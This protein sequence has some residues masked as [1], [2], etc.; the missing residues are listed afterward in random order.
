[1]DIASVIREAQQDP[2]VANALLDAVANLKVASAWWGAE[3]PSNLGRS[4]FTRNGGSPIG[5]VWY[6]ESWDAGEPIEGKIKWFTAPPCIQD[7]YISVPDDLFRRC[8]GGVDVQSILDPYFGQAQDRVDAILRKQ[9][10]IL[11]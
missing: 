9:G 3:N 2:A 10:W 7:G 6:E 4:R 11:P 8:L 1:M 5:R